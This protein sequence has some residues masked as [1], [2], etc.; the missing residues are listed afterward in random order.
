MQGL[1]QFIAEGDSYSYAT[2]KEPAPLEV[3][4]ST[5]S[6]RRAKNL[7]FAPACSFAYPDD[8]DAPAATAITMCCTTALWC[9]TH[10][11]V[12]MQAIE[13][14]SLIGEIVTCTVCGAQY[15]P[16]RE[17]VKRVISL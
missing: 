13:A 3:S 11:E 9:P 5:V 10:R 4:R 7:D 2:V 6:S 16:A 14:H 17:A 15:N 12:I 8:C 1:P